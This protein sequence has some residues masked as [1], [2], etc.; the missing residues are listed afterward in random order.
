M[1][2]DTELQTYLSPNLAQTMVKIIIA[3]IISVLFVALL[4]TMIAA[5]GAHIA[6]FVAYKASLMA[7]SSIIQLKAATGVITSQV[8]ML[9]LAFNKLFAGLNADPV[10]ACIKEVRE[11]KANSEFQYYSKQAKDNVASCNK[12]LELRKKAL[13]RENSLKPFF[14]GKSALEMHEEA[15]AVYTPAS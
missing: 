8:F 1:T 10:K 14:G 3:L 9:G 11:K 6:F 15:T 4:G 2:T 5:P 7:L 12:G 13:R